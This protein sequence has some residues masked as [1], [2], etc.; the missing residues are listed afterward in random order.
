MGLTKSII[1]GEAAVKQEGVRDG[2]LRAKTGPAV[3]D[4]DD[5]TH[6]INIPIGAD[7]VAQGETAVEKGHTHIV[8]VNL[9]KRFGVKSAGH[10]RQS[11]NPGTQRVHWHRFEL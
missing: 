11:L 9:F 2:R 1:D 7:Q 4:V 3:F 10:T 5:H 8:T 6:E